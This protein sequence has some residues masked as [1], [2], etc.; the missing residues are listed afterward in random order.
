MPFLCG[1]LI[2]CLFCLFDDDDD[3]EQ[4]ESVVNLLT[5]AQMAPDCE[6]L[7]LVL[8]TNI[9]YWNWQIGIFCISDAPPLY[10]FKENALNNY[11]KSK[12]DFIFPP[13]NGTR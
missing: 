6:T 7:Q 8:S 4:K 12:E 1:Y 11:L 13:I 9:D 2:C 3:D 10:K 5:P